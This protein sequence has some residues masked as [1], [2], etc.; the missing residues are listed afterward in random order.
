MLG[1]RLIARLWPVATFLVGASCVA[2]PVTE[3]GRAAKD[4]YDSFALIAAVIFTVVAGL[5]GFSIVRFRKKSGDETLPEQFHTN[6][7]L[8]VLWF[9]IP[10]VIVIGLF[11]GSVVVLDDTDRVRD[12]TDVTIDVTAF[13]W[14]WRFEYEGTGMALESLPDARATIVIPVG[15]TIA[16]NLSSHDVIHSFYV[17][18]FFVKRDVVPGRTNRLEVIVDQIGTYT[19]RCAE[20][21]GLLHDSMDFTVEVVDGAGF[22][23]WLSNQVGADG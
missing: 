20:F 13:Q 6:T 12:R 9:A 17:P 14:G 3:Q 1:R 23:K 10:Q 7:K 4:L 21:C 8:E 16:F 15:E 5:I 19:A 22:E 18:E 2:Q 11:I